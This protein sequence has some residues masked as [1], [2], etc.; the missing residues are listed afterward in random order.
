[1]RARVIATA[2]GLSVFLAFAI[3]ERRWPEQAIDIWAPQVRLLEDYIVIPVFGART[4]HGMGNMNPER[5]RR[6]M[7]F[8]MALYSTALGVLVYAAVKMVGPHDEPPVRPSAAIS[9][10]ARPG[11]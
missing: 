11:A 1:M 7:Y 3:V 6:E 4:V 9:G 2:F 8:L 10:S 5:W